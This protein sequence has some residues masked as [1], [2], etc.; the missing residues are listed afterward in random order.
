M[1]IRINSLW[2]C[3]LKGEALQQREKLE[4]DTKLGVANDRWCAL[5]NQRYPDAPSNQWHRKSAFIVGMNDPY[6]VAKRAEFTDGNQLKAT[7][8]QEL[9]RQQ[10]LDYEPQVQYADGTYTLH[11]TPG[12]VSMLNLTTHLAFSEF[13][14]RPLDPR[15]WRMNIWFH[16]PLCSEYTWV[17]ASPGT[18]TA[19]IGLCKIR[20]DHRNI[21]C[22]APGANPRTGENDIPDIEARLSDFMEQCGYGALHRQSHCIMGIMAASENNGIVLPTDGIVLH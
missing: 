13:L 3:N 18:R 19:N 14:G 1:R 16:A 11:D 20:F 22:P 9:M 17:N 21:R 15:R 6:I 4:L 8:V 2:G 12:L 10:N 5:R 7:F